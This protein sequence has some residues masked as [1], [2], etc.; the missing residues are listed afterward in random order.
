M[1]QLIFLLALLL[2]TAA[3]AQKRYDS[4]WKQVEALQEK[5]LPASAADECLA[6]FR[7]A[8][9]HGDFPV[10]LRAFMT[11]ASERQKIHS[12]SL[13]TD[14]NFLYGWMAETKD[15]VESAVLC[16]AALHFLCG[17]YD[18]HRSE[19][20]RRSNTWEQSGS[21]SAENIQDFSEKAPALSPI[22]AVLPKWCARDFRNEALR[23]MALALQ[24][25][26][27]LAGIST[28]TYGALITRQDG[29]RYFAHDLLHL[30]GL[31]HV[32]LLGQIRY[33]GYL[34]EELYNATWQQ[35]LQRLADFYEAR[36]NRSALMLVRLKRMELEHEAY[37]LPD[38]TYEQRLRTLYAEN[39]DMDVAVEIALDLA[40][41][42]QEKRRPAE[43][44]PLCEEAEKRFLHYDRV[45]ALRQI[46]DNILRAEVEVQLDETVTPGDTLT[47]RVAHRNARSFQLKFYPLR[48]ATPDWRNV[49]VGGEKFMKQYA[50][51]P[52]VQEF[53]LTPPADYN[54]RDTVIRVL[55][56]QE[57]TY[58]VRA[59]A[60]KA[61]E[62]DAQ[63]LLYVTRLMPFYIDTHEGD[64]HLYVVDRKSGAPLPGIEVSVYEQNARTSAI[65]TLTTDQEGHIF[66][67]KGAKNVEFYAHTSTDTACPMLSRSRYSGRETQA[68]VRTDLELLTD[69]A[70]YRP[71]Q[72]V[73]IKGIMQ[74]TLGDSTWVCPNEER[75]VKLLDAN[76]QQIASARL[77]TNE[78]GSFDHAFQLPERCMS[79][80]FSVQSEDGWT[81]FRVEE[82]K[83]PSFEIL[84]DTLPEAPHLGDTICLT[85]RAITLSGFPLQGDSVRYSVEREE[86][87]AH[88]WRISQYNA[89]SYGE[90]ETFHGAAVTDSEGR[91]SIELPAPFPKGFDRHD[92]VAYRF[93][94]NITVTDAA[95]ES[96]EKLKTLRIGTKN[97]VLSFRYNSNYTQEVVSICKDSLS[98]VVFKAQDLDGVLRDADIRARI[99]L[100]GKDA[101]LWEETCKANKKSAATFWKKLRSGKYDLHL[102]A[103]A[104]DGDTTR[105]VQPILLFGLHDT[106]VPCDTV[107]WTVSVP[108]SLDGKKIEGN[109]AAFDALVGSSEKNAHLLYSIYT[110]KQVL[111]QRFIS[112][113]DSLLRFSLDYRPEYGDG[114][115]LELYMIKDGELYHR[116]YRLERPAPDKQL[117]LKWTSFRNH[118]QAGQTEEWSLSVSRPDGTP[119]DA[120]L[121]ASLYDAALDQIEEHHIGINHYYSRSIR[122]LTFHQ[123][124]SGTLTLPSY[125]ATKSYRY[126]GFAY[127]QWNFPYLSFRPLIMLKRQNDVLA[128][129]APL[130]AQRAAAA[131]TNTISIADAKQT[132]VSTDEAAAEKEVGY[133]PSEFLAGRI[134]GLPPENSPDPVREDFSESAFFYPTL[135]TDSAGQ[136]RISFT[137]PE[138]LTRWRLVGLAHTR[139]FCT[140]ELDE[141]ITASKP[142]MLSAHLPRYLRQGDEASVSARLLN[143]S[144]ENVKGTVRLELFDPAT[145][146]VLH[147]EKQKFNLSADSSAAYVFTVSTAESQTMIGI[148]LTAD[149]DHF[150][151]GEQHQL[152][153]LPS[154]THLVQA[155]PLTL[156]G[157]GEKE[158][159]L[160]ELFNSG[161]PTATQKQYTVELYANPVW[162][163]VLAL[164]VL[165]TPQN[166]NALD[167]ATAYYANSLSAWL[168]GESQELQQILL[169][170]TGKSA[171]TFSKLMQDSELKAL[172]LEETPWVAEA[173]EEQTAQAA[174]ARLA[175]QNSIRFQITE[176]A[177]RL[178]ALQNG[179]GSFAW[180]PGMRGNAY[181]TRQV[182]EII[183]RLLRLTN[184][185]PE[186]NMKPLLEQA[187]SYLYTEEGKRFDRLTDE[188]KED[189]RLSSVDLD[190]LYL[191]T[192]APAQPEGSA[193]QAKDFYL[194]LLPAAISSFDLGEKAQA[195]TIL[196]EN[197]QKAAARDYYRSIQEYATRT[198]E[199]GSFFAGA[200]SRGYLPEQLLATVIEASRLMGDST[201]TDNLQLNLLRHKQTQAWSNT[202]ANANAVYAL[203]YGAQ[204][205]A[206]SGA[207]C[208]L[209]I[210]DFTL[211]TAAR[212]GS[213]EALMG[214]AK[215]SFPAGEKTPAKAL[216]RKTG[217]GIAW[218]AV[219]GQCDELIDRVKEQGTR[220]KIE[221]ELFVL[222]NKGG[223]ML[224]EKIG[225]QTVLH[226]GD[227]VITRLFVENDRDLDFVYIKDTRASC[228]EPVSQLSGYRQGAYQVE[229][230]AS[231]QLFIDRLERGTHVFEIQ[232]FVEHRGT[233][234]SGTALLQCSYSAE[235]TGHSAALELHVE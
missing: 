160:A 219:Y 119:A 97:L 140:G 151:D 11:R 42:L 172:L 50:G 117:K 231:T 80:Y 162:A 220:V 47:L 67:P 156:R 21:A 203:L 26:A 65:A 141:T 226:T 120:E 16:E 217:E 74:R 184:A 10:Q 94:V 112:F 95:G 170:Q 152:A 130:A 90:A 131:T 164:P 167:L 2:A 139:D 147:E 225:P 37:L 182:V 214:Y 116:S 28:E 105:V 58:V 8:R 66:Y 180:Y 207:S 158:Y 202:L 123:R 29:S 72:T 96:Q 13:L 185:A 150:S 83:R 4:L 113:S 146:R 79:G 210:G 174:V 153:V 222:R 135:R 179:D 186:D 142:F 41:F 39:K 33:K 218:G 18:S 169:Q 149:A 148:R 235:F 114:A 19:I 122:R 188:D 6:I 104:P 24:H 228:L 191:C 85:G 23:L 59:V 9:Q 14:M 177:R 48:L 144:G 196:W 12:D 132:A 200:G 102:E 49:E 213:A 232:S 155:I 101:A 176:M 25:P 57:G 107:F 34:G 201:L 56:P 91:F 125:Q 189:Y 81:G 173:Q 31:N 1:K 181:I 175:D 187:Y 40:R 62:S 183:G 138:S 27:P 118:L 194:G 54:R 63:D 211:S 30:I 98:T 128:S 229:K 221:K 126:P 205:L 87:S 32:E 115:I 178:K 100:P 111:E 108:R 15:T 69:R 166:E 82:Y 3:P 133:W 227:R 109:P 68:K 171:G 88:T 136:V 145:M 165:N 38:S 20:L 77:R 44:L 121:M 127:D 230:D 78:F 161:S 45:K 53:S 64:T 163:A 215:A 17:Y 209:S 103:I 206:G 154:K 7:L 159:D 208:S 190:Y 61:K 35:T 22:S 124:Y 86:F 233:Y 92:Y 129:T 60:E 43:A 71:G 157:E 198:D 134:A 70:I 73:Y 46:R 197:G 110:D 36:G 137:L 224:A 106:E 75:E 89:Y 51:T 99:T 55:A 195:V 93:R 193:A 234:T 143:A 52:L 199:L 223:E 76:N 192:L 5:D 212:P 168:V 84:L 216:F 204:N